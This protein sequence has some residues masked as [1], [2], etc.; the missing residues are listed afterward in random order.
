VSPYI[1]GEKERQR[2]DKCYRDQITQV[3]DILAKRRNWVLYLGHGSEEIASR[4]Q[5][6]VLD[7]VS[8]DSYL[9]ESQSRGRF[10]L[11]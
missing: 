10:S 5:D 1:T 2:L 7:S 4:I 8:Y 6:L 11:V 3:L 9:F